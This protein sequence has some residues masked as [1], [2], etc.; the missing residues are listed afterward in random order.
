M[1]PSSQ[2]KFFDTKSLLVSKTD[3]KG[4]I[5]YVNKNFMDI[6]GYTEKELIGKPHNIVRHPDMPR[7]IFKLLWE[8]IGNGDEIHAYVKNRC[9]DGGF[10]WVLAN[11]TPSYSVESKIIGYHSARRYPQKE[12]L[13][14]IIPLYQKLLELEKNEGIGASEAY[15][16]QL[17]SEKGMSYD[18]FILS[19]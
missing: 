19:I 13:E 9:A 6:A 8:H 3:T 18:E 16:N 5:T 2:E 12:A 17:L 15:L 10:Y 11:V 1:P 4:R 7:L 14:V